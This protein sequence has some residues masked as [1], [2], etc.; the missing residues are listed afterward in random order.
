[1]VRSH[2]NNAQGPQRLREPGVLLPSQ[3]TSSVAMFTTI[4]RGQ[5]DSE[6]VTSDP[7]VPEARDIPDQVRYGSQPSSSVLDQQ[8][9]P[10]PP[11][12]APPIPFGRSKSEL[13][14]LLARGAKSRKDEDP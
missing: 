14:L 1:M 7:V 5:F 9:K 11:N 3:A 6:T 12:P 8:L 10:T 4:A 2:S 13:T